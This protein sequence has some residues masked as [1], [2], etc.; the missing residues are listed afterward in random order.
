MGKRIISQN[1][2]KGS[3]TYRAPS[4][5]YR[6]DIKQIRPEGEGTVKGIVQEIMRDPARS[7]P[8]ALVA[9]NSGEMRYI[10]APEGTYIGQEIACGISAP[11]EPGNTL[12]LAEIPEGIPICNVESQPGHGGQ[13]ARSSGVCAILVAHDVGAT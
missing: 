11:I 7:A 2:G 4:H 9:L 1:R 8:V 5:R 6:A 12:P 3:P 13:F 10:L